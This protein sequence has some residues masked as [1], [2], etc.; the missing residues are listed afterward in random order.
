MEEQDYILFEDYVSG[1]LSEEEKQ[2]LEERLQYDDELKESFT[3]YKEASV[4]LDRT[5]GKTEDTEA[6]RDKIS[7][8]SKEYFRKDTEPSKGIRKLRPWQI[9]V[10]ASIL[11][12]LGIFFFRRTGMPVYEDY[13]DY[14]QLSLTVRGG[15]NTLLKQAETAFNEGDYGKASV[16]FEDILKADRTNAEIS[17]YYAVSLVELGRYEEADTGFSAL[18]ASRSVF[19]TEAIWYGALSKLRQKD[20]KASAG[21]LE[22]IPEG[23]DRYAQAQ[24]LLKKL[25]E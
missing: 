21:L 25:P 12:I 19:R 11:V 18:M 16:L 3:V 8:I 22:Q 9:A 13:A 15:E 24:K 10:A 5:F 2:K 1:T 7:A 17:F 23:D 14:P 4:Y 6:F 20:Y